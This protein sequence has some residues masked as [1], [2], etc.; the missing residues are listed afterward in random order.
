MDDEEKP[1]TVGIA[2]MYYLINVF[3]NYC[4]VM[5]HGIKVNNITFSR[6]MIVDT[7][8]PA[9]YPVQTQCLGPP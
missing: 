2:H 7:I 5:Y 6:S 3:P 4:M 9:R 8:F 1:T